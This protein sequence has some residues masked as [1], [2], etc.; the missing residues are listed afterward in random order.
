MMYCTTSCIIIVFLVWILHTVAI[1][2]TKQRSYDIILFGDFTPSLVQ[3][4][5]T[6]NNSDLVT[7][8]LFIDQVTLGLL[9][10]LGK[11]LHIYIYTRGL[12]HK[13]GTKNVLNNEKMNLFS[14]S[15]FTFLE[16]NHTLS[17]WI[18]FFLSICLI[19][20]CNGRKNLGGTRFQNEEDVTNAITE[21]FDEKCG[22]YFRDGIFKLLHRWKKWINLNG[23]YEEE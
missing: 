1:T 3:K 23:D 6:S 20:Q 2:T 5:M 4:N 18:K 11:Y 8:N 19:L 7:S 15:S 13:K 22:A 12:S 16:R 9:T 14:C 21:Y 10:V 17:S